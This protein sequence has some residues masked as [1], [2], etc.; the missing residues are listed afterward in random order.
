MCRVGQL[1]P[2]EEPDAHPHST[3]AWSHPQSIHVLL[4][5]VEL[6]GT[7]VLG[8]FGIIQATSR[9]DWPGSTRGFIHFAI[10][11]ICIF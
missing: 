7:P 1:G 5:E 10:F 2:E 4:L 6:E 11:F 3:L 8:D 9:M